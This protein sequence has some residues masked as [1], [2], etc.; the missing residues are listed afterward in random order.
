MKHCSAPPNFGQCHLLCYQLVPT[1]D[2]L[3]LFQ[4][5]ASSTKMGKNKGVQPHKK[6]N[7]QPK[8][9]LPHQ[10]SKAKNKVFAEEQGLA[11]LLQLSQSIA[12][13]KSSKQAEL[14]AKAQ[15]RQAQAQQAQK[16]QDSSLPPAQKGMNTLARQDV[17]PPPPTVCF[18]PL[19]FI[20]VFVGACWRRLEKLT[21]LANRNWP[22][23]KH[24]SRPKS[25][26]RGSSEK[27]AG[28]HNEHHLLHLNLLRPKRPMFHQLLRRPSQESRFRSLFKSMA[29]FGHL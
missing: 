19:S 23:S 8:K 10:P 2:Q 22:R 14:V 29:V 13:Q 20:V 24:R 12:Q 11:H 6:D 7:V 4:H 9:K 3:L 21:V 25:G 1:N 17:A 15:A 28:K 18:Y 26:R 16:E 27:K 5:T